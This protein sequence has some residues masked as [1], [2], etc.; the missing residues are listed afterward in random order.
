MGVI[1]YGYHRGFEAVCRG[2][3]DA[4]SRRE[5]LFLAQQPASGAG[6]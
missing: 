6:G 4:I 3:S 1:R 5:G 2:T